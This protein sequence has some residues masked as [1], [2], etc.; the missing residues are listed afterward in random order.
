MGDTNLHIDIA[1]TLGLLLGA[2]LVA[3]VF[4]ELPFSPLAWAKLIVRRE[5]GP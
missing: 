3:G 2:C 4:A 1:S 5:Y